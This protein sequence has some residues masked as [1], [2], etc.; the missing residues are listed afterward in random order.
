MDHAKNIKVDHELSVDGSIMEEQKY[1]P[2]STSANLTHSMV[3]NISSMSAIN[4]NDNLTSS[5]ESNKSSSSTTPSSANN[6]N[7]ANG[8]KHNLKNKN[9][10]NNIIKEEEEED[11][12]EEEEEEKND[13][14]IDIK[15]SKGIILKP[16]KATN[17]RSTQL[18]LSMPSNLQSLRP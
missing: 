6:V 9:I 5:S 17:K 15:R 7:N 3:S 11:D 12:E 16:N 4:I 18:P 2:M 1:P 10:G 13:I 14:N 8:Y